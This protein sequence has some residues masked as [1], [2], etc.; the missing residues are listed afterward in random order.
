MSSFESR[1]L[2]L[3]MVILDVL[4]VVLSAALMERREEVSLKLVLH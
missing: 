2:S 4:P 3:V 1:P